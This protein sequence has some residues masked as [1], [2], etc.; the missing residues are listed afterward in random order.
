[1]SAMEFLSEEVRAGL[2]A[3]RKRDARRRA[4][5]RVQVGEDLYP[6]L[7]IWETGFALDAEQVPH[8]RGHVDIF[9]GSR[10]LMQ[11][12]IVASV[13]ERGELVCDFKWSRP[14]ADVPPVDFARDENAP[15]GLLPKG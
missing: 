6:V 3:A 10:H 12:L 7:R 8:L 1:M 9:D 11:C 5:L 4:R 15:V 14:T 2:E 13:E